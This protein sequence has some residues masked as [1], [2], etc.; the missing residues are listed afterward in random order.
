[1]EKL[2]TI[3]QVIGYFDTTYRPSICSKLTSK[4]IDP[5]IQ[6]I[7]C[8]AKLNTSVKPVEIKV[9]NVTFS[10]RSEFLLGKNFGEKSWQYY[11]YSRLNPELIPEYLE[12]WKNSLVSEHL[13]IS[14]LQNT[15]G[16]TD[17]KRSIDESKLEKLTREISFVDKLIEKENVKE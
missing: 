11:L 10:T 3:D 1:M 12:L 2:Y 17:L 5:D 6:I 14:Q 8:L 9:S 16:I 7:N 4:Q 13:T 15:P